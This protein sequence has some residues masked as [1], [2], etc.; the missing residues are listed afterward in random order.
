MNYVL[1]TKHKKARWIGRNRKEGEKGSQTKSRKEYAKLEQL[2]AKW[3][4]SCAG[5]FCQWASE[6]K[7]VKYYIEPVQLYGSE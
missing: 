5:D 1:A 2:S 7:V 6:E 4:T 3:E